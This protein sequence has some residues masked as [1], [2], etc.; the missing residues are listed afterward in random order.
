MSKDTNLN[1]ITDNV[2]IEQVDHIK[3]LGVIINSKLT[4]H[5]HMKLVSSKVSKSI[6][7]LSKISYNLSSEIW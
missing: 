3:F 7:L 2:K 4:W 1:L 6:G 5:D